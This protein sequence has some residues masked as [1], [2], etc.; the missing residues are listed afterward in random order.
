MRELGNCWWDLQSL[1]QNLSLTLKADVLGPANETGKVS[2]RRK[3]LTDTEVS[4]S[5]LEES[6]GFG[7]FG[8]SFTTLALLGV[9]TSNS[10][11]NLES[12]RGISL[13]DCLLFWSH[14]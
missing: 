6:F 11:F 4:C 7:G 8:T 5:L 14:Q 13:C 3:V 9:S 1:V 10:G 12:L 2:A